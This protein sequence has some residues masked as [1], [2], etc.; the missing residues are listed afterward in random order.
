MYRFDTSVHQFAGND[1]VGQ[2]LDTYNSVINGIIQRAGAIQS[3]KQ[4]EAAFPLLQKKLELDNE[5]QSLTNDFNSDTMDLR[6]AVLKTGFES[7]KLGLEEKRQDLAWNGSFLKKSADFGSGYNQ[8]TQY[9][10]KFDRPPTAEAPPVANEEVMRKAL[11]VTDQPKSGFEINLSSYTPGKGNIKMEGGPLDAH[12]KPAYTF[13]QFHSG[14]APYVA[15]A[16]DPNSDLQGKTLTSDKFPDTIFKVV[17]TG[18]AFKGKGNSRMDIAF[19]DP[20]RQHSFPIKSANFQV[21]NGTYGF[22]SNNG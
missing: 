13:E 9:L 20:A 8:M 10:P 12:G 16:M 7:A 5:Q 1:P 22:G 18:D 21:A 2:V 19:S 6:K 17:D 3:I 15:V 11:P 14:K 4:K